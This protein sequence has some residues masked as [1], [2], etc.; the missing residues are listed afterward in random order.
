MRPNRIWNNP[1]AWS[2]V[3]L[4]AVIAVPLLLAGASRDADESETR[5]QI[6]RMTQPERER[7]ERNSREFLRLPPAERDRLRQLHEA[8]Q[9]D[10]PNGPLNAAL[11]KYE[12]WS[13][14]LSPWQRLE[15]RNEP[16]PDK[17]FEMVSSIRREQEEIRAKER[18]REQ[19][20]L[21][22]RQFFL[23]RELER[24]RDGAIRL[25]RS[26]LKA[27]IE[28]IEASLPESVR[29]K[30]R[31]KAEGPEQ[32]LEVLIAALNGHL[33]NCGEDHR[34][35]DDECSRCN[36]RWPGPKLMSALVAE[37]DDDAERQWFA[38][39]AEKGEGQ[40]NL[41][42][43]LRYGIISAWWRWQRHRDFTDGQR[44]R[45]YEELDDSQRNEFQKLSPDE[46]R[47]FLNR[48]VVADDWDDLQSRLAELLRL[49]LKLTER[50]GFVSLPE[51]LRAGQRRLGDVPPRGSSRPESRR[52][53][54]LDRSAEGPDRERKPGR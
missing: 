13:N 40:P 16:D 53:G 29:G 46:R 38:S 50:G 36:H 17:R 31:D 20:E 39:L 2:A 6:E 5:A 12:Q 22:R 25:G 28:H 15:L 4:A 34:C 42:A 19:E 21:E 43:T 52:S 45:E 26:E 51:H 27:M 30:L 24:E 23:S 48:Q 54:G 47:R 14:T 35:R 37:I 18:Q 8:L 1:L 10:G 3:G 41:V 32:Y 49:S 33:E 11:R 7:L 9:Q 44:E